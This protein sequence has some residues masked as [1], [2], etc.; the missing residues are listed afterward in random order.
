MSSG[1]GYII[2]YAH[3]KYLCEFYQFNS[4][5]LIMEDFLIKNRAILSYFLL[6]NVV[7]MGTFHIDTCNL[8]K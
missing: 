8:M 4:Y 5:D 3:L 2:L 1:Y 7:L 6:K